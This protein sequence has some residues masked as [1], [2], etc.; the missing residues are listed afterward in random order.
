M[1]FSVRTKKNITAISIPE[2][3]A[4]KDVTISY[5]FVSDGEWY[6]S[7][8][9]PDYFDLMKVSIPDL[10]GYDK[11]KTI[12]DKVKDKFMTAA[13]KRA[14]AAAERDLAVPEGD[15]PVI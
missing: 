3:K 15:T 5:S 8:I 1:L 14:A 10:E 7:E 4:G 2:V 6:V 13:E 12:Y 11:T 9:D